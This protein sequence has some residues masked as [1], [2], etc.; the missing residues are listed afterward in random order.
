M[1]TAIYQADRADRA[2]TLTVSLATI[3]VTTT[4]L[5]G[6]IAFYDKLD[7]LGWAIS[8]LPFP[9]LCTAAF[10]AQLLNLAAVRAR[11]I[12]TLERALLAATDHGESHS[13][14]PSRIGATAAEHATNIHTAG[15]PLRLAMLIAYSGA[16]IIP[17]AYTALMLV[18]A[19]HHLGGWVAVPAALYLILLVPIVFAWRDS[20]TKLDFN[21]TANPTTS[22]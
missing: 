10:H 1:L 15:T 12:L 8:L 2:T 9:L 4:Y 20:A 16:G 6:T 14:D 18:K 3:G 21:A 19:A 22:A 13:L 7:L 11:S 17:L 5:I